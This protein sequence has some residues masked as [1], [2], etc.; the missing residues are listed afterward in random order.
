M[1]YQAFRT[2]MRDFTVFSLRDIMRVY[3]QFDRRRL[4]EWQDKGYI[5]K[6]IKGFYVT[7]DLPLD[8][9]V[10]FEIA[11]RIYKPS[12]VS[13]ESALAYYQLI[14]ES[15]FEVTSVSTRRTYRFPEGLADFRFRTVRPDLFF[16]YE[17]IPAARGRRVK[18]A[19]PAKA[20]LDLLYLNPH[21]KTVSD[22]KSLRI[23]ADRFLQTVDVR[24]L[25]KAA[26]RYAR[27]AFTD[28]VDV[29]LD[30]LKHGS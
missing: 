20:L 18:M 10:L 25:R 23:D 8:E 29:F 2:S 12:Y 15:V 21:L 26:D 19:G 3:P 14:P 17:L 6:V 5:R 24:D 22:F 1:N 27:K 16:G 11:N 7:S 28:R 9:M 4:S 13:L 30:D